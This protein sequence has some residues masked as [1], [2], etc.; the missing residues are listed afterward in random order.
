MEPGR[1]RF[2]QLRWIET[3]LER[4]EDLYIA[5]DVIARSVVICGDAVWR[6]VDPARLMRILVR[7]A[8]RAPAVIVT[9][10]ASDVPR[11]AVEFGIPGGG[12]ILPD[13]DVRALELLFGRHGL[14]PTFSGTMTADPR[15]ITKETMLAI[16]D[17][18]PLKRS[19]TP[20]DEFRPL[21]IVGTYNDED[22]APQTVF[23]LLEDGIDV[24]VLDNWSTDGTYEQL[25][26][27][28]ARFGRLSI[29][30]FPASG[31][32]EFHEWDAVLRRKE[33][34]AVQHPERWIIHH[35]SDEIRRSPW[36]GISLRGG[37]YIAEQMQFTA[38]DFTVCEFRPVDD[39]FSAGMDPET[40]I[41]HF[42]FGQRA[43]HFEQVKAW[44]QGP[45]CVDLASSAGHQ[46][47]FDGRKVFPYKFILKHY[48]L[49]SPAQ[50]RRKVFIE[51]RGRFAPRLRDQGWHVQYD[52]V[53][54][55]DRFIWNAS[56]LIEFD[57]HATR[58]S[59]VT[60]LIAGIGRS[61]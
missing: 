25:K 3:D 13:E 50:A 12:A 7:F 56:E 22:V 43:D 37:L 20:P 19:G 18:C 39:Q 15:C 1:R 34:I 55:D 52:D 4:S 33:E 36:A 6:L 61:R 31:P 30:R 46:A 26:V 59:Y 58:R 38:I 9:M 57:E 54:L 14:V 21:A 10:S 40:M 51:R 16:L 5:D 47:W 45:D 23:K 49:R 44:R 32:T 60:E 2:P 28:S 17:C 27:L 35:D 48:P 8:G 29:E 42:E 53:N 41:R 11:D 24:H